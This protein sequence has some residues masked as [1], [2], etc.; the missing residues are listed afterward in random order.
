MLGYLYVLRNRGITQ[1]NEYRLPVDGSYTQEVKEKD[2]S[3]VRGDFE[4]N[5]FVTAVLEHIR[6]K[7]ALGDEL[8]AR[9][10]G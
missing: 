8:I 5:S 6:V 7:E 10:Q 4:S 3:E 9:L 1:V 2:F